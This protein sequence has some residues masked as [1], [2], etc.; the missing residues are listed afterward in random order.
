MH[1]NIFV[2]SDGRKSVGVGVEKGW[3]Y[4]VSE[5]AKDKTRTFI[6]CLFNGRVER[7]DRRGPGG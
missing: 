1:A 7:M 6:L 2:P 3:R 4:E 5:T